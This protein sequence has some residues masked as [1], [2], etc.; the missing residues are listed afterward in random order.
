MVCIF[1]NTCTYVH[2]DVDSNDERLCLEKIFINV[3]QALRF[4]F[5]GFSQFQ[6]TK[7][8]FTS[9]FTFPWGNYPLHI[10]LCFISILPENIRKLEVNEREMD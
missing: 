4:R 7:L 10:N 2:K 9:S 5:V 3:F 6:L 8:N 1:V